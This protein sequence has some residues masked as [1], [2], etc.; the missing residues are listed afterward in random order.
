M[1][2]RAEK[3]FRP[4]T[5]DERKE[6]YEKEFSIGKVKS[7]FKSNGMKLPQLCALDAGSETGIMLDKRW[8]NTIFYFPFSELKEKIK[9]Y[10]PED[11]YYDRNVYK[12][13]K[14]ILKKLQFNKWIKQELAFDIDLDNIKCRCKKKKR[15]CSK[16]LNKLFKITQKMKKE[17]EKI[18]FKKL[19]LVYSGRGFHIHALD[20]KAYSFS[21]KERRNLNKK[22]AKYPIDPWVSR[23]YIRLM[24]MPYSLHGVVSRMVIPIKNSFQKEKTIPN[25]LS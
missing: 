4:A 19:I 13:P 3:E 9:K 18:G 11:L 23:G 17:L 15:V 16:C 1:K 24:R 8:K 5:L 21:I 12:N 25:F 22:F 2:K 10:N 20:E 14:K 7:W 6:F